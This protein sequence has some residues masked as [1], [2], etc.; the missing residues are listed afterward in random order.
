ML[1]PISPQAADFKVRERII[2]LLELYPVLSHSMIGIGLGVQIPAWMWRPELQLLIN[3]GIVSRD[4]VVAQSVTGRLQT[5][6][7]L[8]LVPPEKR[9][10]APLRE[11]QPSTLEDKNSPED[12]NL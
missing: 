7:Q 4:D 3:E 12:A 10:V 6:T 2:H 11:P 8:T 5:Y 1:Q 9:P